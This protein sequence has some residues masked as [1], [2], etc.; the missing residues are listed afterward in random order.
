MKKEKS[1]GADLLRLTVNF[2]LIEKKKYY[3]KKAFIYTTN[4][5]IDFRVLIQFCNV[6]LNDI[7]L[8]I[9]NKN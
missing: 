5:V 3:F 6:D 8:N 7:K 2:T 4:E 9:T 1:T